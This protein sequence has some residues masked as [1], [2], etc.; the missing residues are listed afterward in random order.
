MIIGVVIT[1]AIKSDEK[2]VLSGGLHTLL[3]INYTHKMGTS[4][5]PPTSIIAL[6][7]SIYIHPSMIVFSRAYTFGSWAGVVPSPS[8]RPP[9]PR[10]LIDFEEVWIRFSW[11]LPVLDAIAATSRWDNDTYIF[12]GAAALA[13]DLGPRIVSGLAVLQEEPPL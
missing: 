6:G 4:L 7:F 2:L 12:V 11:A 8:T 1:T 10:T 9:S 3:Y 13:C 5:L